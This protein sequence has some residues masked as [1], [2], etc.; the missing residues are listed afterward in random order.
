MKGFS[1]VPIILLLFDLLLFKEEFK[2]QTYIYSYLN[3]AARI[4]NK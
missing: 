3:R 2:K 1:P 4:L